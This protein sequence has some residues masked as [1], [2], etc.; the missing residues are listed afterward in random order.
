MHRGRLRQQ[1]GH[2]RGP[3]RGDQRHRG[4]ER[5]RQRAGTDRGSVRP[6]VV[7]PRQP[8]HRSAHVRVQSERGR[9]GQRGTTDRAERR[10]LRHVH[11]QDRVRVPRRESQG[12]RGPGHP[13]LARL[14]AKSPPLVRPEDNARHGQGDGHGPGV[15]RARARLLFPCQPEEVRRLAGAVVARHCRLQ[16][17][18]QRRGGGNDGACRRLPAD[19]HGPRQRDAV[20][21]PSRHHERRRS[22]TSRRLTRE[23]LLHGPQGEGV[24]LQPTGRRLA[25]DLDS[26]ATALHAAVPVVGVYETMPTPGYDYQSWMLAEVHAIESAVEH[27]VSTQ[28]L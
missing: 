24:L 9:R 26:R 27:G 8:Q 3:T 14:H 10:R 19:S 5:V 25:H 11:E 17:A 16:G 21:L 2:A 28:H 20:A 22:L 6:C 4:G 12:D 7:G 18:L 13:R 1:R 23:Q 15:T